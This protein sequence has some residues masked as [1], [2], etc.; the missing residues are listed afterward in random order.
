MSPIE[1]RNFFKW[2]LENHKLKRSEA[3]KLIQYI[4]NNSMILEN[5]SFTEDI[6]LSKK[7]IV[8]SSMNSDEPGFLF[9]NHQRKTDEVSMALSDLMMNPSEK[10]NMIIHFRGKMLNYRYLQL[11]GNPVS[12]HIKEYERFKKYEKE[13]DAIIEKILLEKEIE[14]IKKRIDDALDQK[15]EELFKRLTAKLKEHYAKKTND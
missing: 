4:V 1:K 3:R 2:F 9:Y 10:V 15:D 5:I 12:D 7:T 11:I 8:I 14:L 13:A 6:V